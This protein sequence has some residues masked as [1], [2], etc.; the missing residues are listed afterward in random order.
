MKCYSVSPK[1]HRITYLPTYLP[2]HLSKFHTD[3]RLACRN[4]R[5]EQHTRSDT[6]TTTKNNN[7]HTT[8]TTNSYHN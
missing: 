1:K 7:N 6:A 3:R 5:D 4:L 2:S 8:N